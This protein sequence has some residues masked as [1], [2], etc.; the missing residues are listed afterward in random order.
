MTTHI[1]A[2]W[3][4]QR[5]DEAVIALAERC[6]LGKGMRPIGADTGSVFRTDAAYRTAELFA[7][8]DHWR[9]LIAE[10]RAEE[11]EA[12]ARVCDGAADMGSVNLRLMR[13]RLAS[14]LLDAPQPQAEPVNAELLAALKAMLEV[15]GVTEATLLASPAMP[16]SWLEVSD[17][18][19][20]AIAR[21]EAQ[22][23]QR[24]TDAEIKSALTEA[25]RD[26]RLSWMG[27]EKDHHGY[28][29]V[30]SLAPYHYQLARAIELRITGD[31]Q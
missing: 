13:N 3:T 1:T 4:I 18:A 21:A 20:A 8:A 26:G 11:R 23:P 2:D 9:R 31:N 29:T 6:G 22:K 15:H 30:P 10:A 17:M 7:F 16:R 14:A 27:F 28:Y 5:D 24:L 12:C 19:R 25:V